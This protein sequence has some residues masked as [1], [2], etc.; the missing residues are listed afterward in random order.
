MAVKVGHN[1]HQSRLP[2]TLEALLRIKL[3]WERESVDKDK[4]CF[5][6]PSL[7]VSLAS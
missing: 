4:K 3:A 2:I 1:I 7:L 6:Q 5:G